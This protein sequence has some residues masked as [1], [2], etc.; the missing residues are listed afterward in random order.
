MFSKCKG[1]HQSI[2]AVNLVLS[3]KTLSGPTCELANMISVMK[4]SDFF[5]ESD[6]LDL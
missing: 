2:T 4:N 6:R 3:G 1:W 5:A